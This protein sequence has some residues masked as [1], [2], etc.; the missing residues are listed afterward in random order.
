MED[1]EI[2]ELYLGRDEQALS[3]TMQRYGGRLLRLA[4]HFLKDKRDAEECVSDTYVKAWNSIPPNRP[5]DLF[6]YLARICRCT[7][8]NIV[9][10]E[11]AQ[12]RSAQLVE[13]TSE[14]AECLPDRSADMEED[15]LSELL[16]GFLETLDRDKRAVFTGRYIFGDSIAEISKK[17]GFSES[18]VK[19][20]LHRTRE[21]L[22]KYLG[23]NGGTP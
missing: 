14:L 6:A 8:F 21:S 16:N 22:R 2:V 4:E 9:E 10:R 12:K 19:T 11:Q 18:K 3:E 7:A 1:K 17:T 5:D 13:L 23:R 20:M 15:G